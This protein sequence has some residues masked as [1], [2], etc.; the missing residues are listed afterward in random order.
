MALALAVGAGCTT[1][2]PVYCD[3]DTPCDDPVLTFCDTDGEAG[4][5]ANT[6]I[7]PPND[8]VDAG[9]PHLDAGV[10]ASSVDAGGPASLA[11]DI[12]E[13]DF[14]S[15]VVG[16]QSASVAFVVSNVGD[17]PTGVIS[18][19]FT[20]DSD[21]AAVTET[22]AGQSLNPS[23]TCQ[24]EM[25]FA[26]GSA[27]G[28]MD[29]F[30]VEAAPGGEL[31]VAMTGMGLAP[32]ALSMAP[33]THDFGT[34]LLSATI[35]SQTLTVTNTGESASG[36][37]ATMLSNPTD[38]AISADTCTGNTLAPSATC[39]VTAQFTPGAVGSK[40]GS[41]T[42][43]ATPGGASATSVAGTGAVAISVTKTGTG[44]GV[45]TSTPSGISCGA[46]CAGTFSSSPVTLSAAPSAGSFFAAWSGAGCAGT[47]D[48][49]VTADADVNVTATFSLQECAPSSV[50]CA[51]G[52]LITCDSIGTIESSVDCSLDCHP[53]EDRCNELNPSNGLASALDDSAAGP[54]LTLPNGSTID[55]DT[56]I[57]TN[58]ETLVEIP[59][60]Q[61]V[62][63]T[64]LPVEVLV[65]KVRS[66]TA[67]DVEVS[68]QRALAIV[69]DG[70]IDL[71]GQFDVSG[72]DRP[73]HEATGPG[74]MVG[75]GCTG[76]SGSMSNCFFGGGGGGAFGDL[77]GRRGGSAG[78]RAYAPGGIGEGN[79]QLVPLRG[80]CSGGDGNAD[81]AGGGGGAVQLVSRSEVRVRGAAFVN[82]S[83]GSG[84][85][86][87][88]TKCIRTD[89][90]LGFAASGGGGGSGGAI[91]LEAPVV[92]LESV[93]GMVANGGGG[94][95]GCYGGS[96][97]VG[98]LST[99]P[100]PGG[101]CSALSKYGSGGDGASAVAVAY[102]GE[103][104]SGSDPLGGGGGGGGVGRVRINTAEG[105][106][107]SAGAIMSPLP[108]V[109]ILSTR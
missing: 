13:Q 79:A 109:G 80:G 36:V 66:F 62:L 72:H 25:R 82:A 49:V 2:N 95:G 108:S 84:S 17:E 88:T 69:S 107:T 47:G 67:F 14:G 34:V 92:V 81:G 39:T 1:K 10:D 63:T 21:F 46:G 12:A 86:S 28:Q 9:L 104:V 24:I 59:V 64:G 48:C 45:V 20:P 16:N 74:A 94:G 90:G 99:T 103:S 75:T 102:D 56:G 76:G 85:P 98:L 38:F 97:A 61:D 71:R 96:G 35:P 57:V 23:Q 42:V 60:P 6:C 19:A 87:V 33:G 54:V 89:G 18:V 4:G 50:T 37:I 73:L 91:L 52:Q 55:T 26:P 106:F 100:A 53:V 40:A 31:V 7:A 83:G 101:D 8:D 43:D 32:G 11:V 105:T 3:G 70:D 51:G 30:S 78:G 77:V 58:G 65:L 93:G 29:D 44:V 68:G 5:K 41:V 22:C 15:V 27:G